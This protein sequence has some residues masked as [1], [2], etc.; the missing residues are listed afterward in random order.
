MIR[1]I[2]LM[3]VVNL[4]AISGFNIGG[5]GRRSDPFSTPI[6][7]VPRRSLV[8]GCSYQP[9]FSIIKDARY[10]RSTS[11][12]NEFYPFLRL[13][14]FL[15]L[16]F[17]FSLNK[18]LDQDFDL[19]TVSQDSLRRQI[20]GR[21]GVISLDLGC[22]LTYKNIVLGLV[23]NII[24]G[25]SEEEWIFESGGIVTTDTLSYEYDGEG[26]HLQA[27]FLTEDFGIIGW[28]G[29]EEVRCDTVVDQPKAYGI[30]GNYRLTRNLVIGITINYEDWLN[31]DDK[32]AIK[33]S[34]TKGDLTI[35]PFYHPWYYGIDEYGIF[36]QLQLLIK[37][38][39]VITPS[40]AVSLRK[41]LGITEYSIIPAI[42]LQ[43][44]ELVKKRKRW[45]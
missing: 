36:F 23:R 28:G 44:N 30:S 26:Y 39:G 12:L 17:I 8:L 7:I 34:L 24:F 40:L 18:Y 33:I 32:P 20:I 35:S 25:T 5:L 43:I 15:G 42:N 10:L 6:S 38:V 45:Y 1:S 29:R 41:G 4:Y 31:H 37:K 16:D 27:G 19:I 2:I 11:D 9:E 21:G 3:V 14:F 22:E 13:P